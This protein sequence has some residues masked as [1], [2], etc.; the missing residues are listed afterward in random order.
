MR[1]FKKANP[2]SILVDWLVQKPKAAFID[3]RVDP[4]HLNALD[5]I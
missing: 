4:I 2:K 5:I 1:I 3:M